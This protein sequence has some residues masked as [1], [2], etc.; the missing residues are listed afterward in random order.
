MP[1]NHDLANTV[2]DK[3]DLYEL[4]NYFITC[5]DWIQEIMCFLCFFV[6]LFVFLQF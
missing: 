2:L 4:R 5:L 3:H 6:C 1:Q